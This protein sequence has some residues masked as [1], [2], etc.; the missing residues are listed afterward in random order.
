MALTF[1]NIFLSLLIY[2]LLFTPQ[3][4][5]G[6]ETNRQFHPSS[7]VTSPDEQAE[8][9][10]RSLNSFSQNNTVI[11]ND[12]SSVVGASRL[13]ERRFKFLFL[14]L[15]SP[16]PQNS[17]HH[18][19]YYALPNT[20]GARMFYFFFESRNNNNDDPVVLW[21]SG[22]PGGSS[23]IALFYENG[24][25]LITEHRTLISNDY[26]WDKISNIIYVDQPTGTGFSY[27]TDN[28][29]IRHDLTAVS[30]DLYHFLQE[31]F[32]KRSELSQKDFF[33]TG[34][35][36]AGHYVPA[37]AS[38]IQQGKKAKEGIPIRLKGI[39][40]GNGHTN[41]GIQYPSI[42]RYARGRSLINQSEYLRIE[43]DLIPQC[44]SSTKDCDTGIDN[45]CHTA[46]INC[47]DIVQAIRDA[48]GDLNFYDTRIQRI[49]TSNFD[50]TNMVA[51]LNMQSVKTAL[52]VGDITFV[53]W[54]STVFGQ[55]IGEYMKNLD[56]KIP[57][58]LKDEIK[59]LI[60]AGEYDLIC[61]WIG[62]LD[63]VTEMEWDGKKKFGT[64]PVNL[65]FVDGAKAGSLTSYGDLAFI[66]VF[67]SSHMVPT[68][69]PK[70]AY[71]MIERWMKGE[72]K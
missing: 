23:S 68:D 11:V 42:P 46:Y 41:P 53:A 45:A 61:N 39:A 64:A 17:H 60:Y 6:T 65:F 34:Q 62:N 3:F 71:H 15:S 37:L 30:N 13:A 58:L 51:F 63:W 32:K 50:Y 33:I 47:N 69:Q 67:N 7:I 27:T 24:P 57:P 31:F 4:L 21:L 16:F 8:K 28:S 70:V 20:K 9:I 52:G 2:D 43:K 12:N 19:G 59:V 25:F 55:M 5:Y 49:G 54:S 56:V 1:V 35:S 44:I 14:P 36:Y 10:I 38:R 26:G 72:L 66:K 22:G 48:T 40:I 29:D 18:V